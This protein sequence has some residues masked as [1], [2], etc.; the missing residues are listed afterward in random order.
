MPLFLQSRQRRL[1]SDCGESALQKDSHAGRM[2]VNERGVLRTVSHK[3]P[4]GRRRLHRGIVP[5]R[6]HAAE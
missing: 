5:G 1:A 3:G 2:R 4:R 6:Q